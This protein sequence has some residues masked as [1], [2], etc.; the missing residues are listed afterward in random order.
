MYFSIEY[1]TPTASFEHTIRNE[2]SDIKA[3]LTGI[4]AFLET[5]T[6]EVDTSEDIEQVRE[7]LYNAVDE[8]VEE[9]QNDG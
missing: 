8:I 9:M 5:V 4:T 3:V 2:E 1:S 6:E 7:N